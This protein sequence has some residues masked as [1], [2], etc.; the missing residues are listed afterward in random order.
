[1][2]VLDAASV[3]ISGNIRGN[4]WRMKTDWAFEN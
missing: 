3:D 2:L 4:S 1:M